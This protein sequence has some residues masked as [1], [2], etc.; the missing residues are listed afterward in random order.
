M[1]SNS[2]T[3]GQ[4]HVGDKV[5]RLDNNCTSYF[6]VKKNHD[7]KTGDLPLLVN[8]QGFTRDGKVSPIDTLP[9]LVHATKENQTMLQS[10]LGVQFAPLPLEGDDLVVALLDKGVKTVLCLK[11]GKKI[12]IDRITAQ[13]GLANDSLDNVTGVTPIDWLTNKPLTEQDLANIQQQPIDH[14]KV[15]FES[16]PVPQ[17]TPVAKSDAV[18]S[19]IA[20]AL[21][22][23][24]ADAS[25]P[26]HTPKVLTLKTTSKVVVNFTLLKSLLEILGDWQWAK[27]K[28]NAMPFGL[29]IYP[30]SKQVKAVSS[31][32]EYSTFEYPQLTPHDLL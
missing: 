3:A 15:H 7:N 24:Q 6:V 2:K 17:A 4:F 25:A 16:K 22:A 20:K 21:K 32:I 30:T 8:G 10:L 28:D 13:G 1:N 27:P 18:Q 12:I 11:D 26:P 31:L 19:C 14:D 23:T 5:Y 29:V 9:T